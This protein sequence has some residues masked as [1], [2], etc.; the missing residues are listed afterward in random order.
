MRINVHRIIILPVVLFGYESWSTLRE[1]RRPMMFK[2]RAL[3][4]IFGTKEDEVTGYR[5]RY[6]SEELNG[7]YSSINIIRVI[8][9]KKKEI[10]LACGMCEERRGACRVL[11]RN[12]GKHT[13]LGRCRRT[14][15]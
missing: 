8:K 7:L 12:P 10:G 2:Y 13:P 15:V 4:K 1:E 9:K 3:R 6:H 11:V 14:R 5:R